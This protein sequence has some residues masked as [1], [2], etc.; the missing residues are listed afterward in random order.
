[1][2]LKRERTKTVDIPNDPDKGS[3]TI[4]LLTLHELDLIE[5]KSSDLKLG[6]D[7]SSMSLKPTKRANAVAR[8][9]I[10]GWDNFF[11]ENGK[12]LKYSKNRIQLTSAFEVD[13]S[14]KTVRFFEW[15]DDEHEKFRKEV[16]EQEKVSVKN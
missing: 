2:R 10:E 6:E 3:V 12:P 5:E 11:N 9:C 14:D 13:L 16:T 8:A 1:M 7:D 4:K 15:V